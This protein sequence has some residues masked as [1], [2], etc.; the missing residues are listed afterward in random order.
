MPPFG[1]DGP[2]EVEMRSVVTRGRPGG[3]PRRRAA[4]DAADTASRDAGEPGD[5]R[6]T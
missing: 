6:P 4:G 2:A 3:H 5:R 1:R